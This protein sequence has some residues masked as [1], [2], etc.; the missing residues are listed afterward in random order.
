MP[1]DL[2]AVLTALAV[3]AAAGWGKDEAPFVDEA[4][5]CAEF[6]QLRQV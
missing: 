4:G 3:V 1:R 6:D 2:V 5:R